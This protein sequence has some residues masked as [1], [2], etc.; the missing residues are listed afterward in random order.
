MKTNKLFA[1][2]FFAIVINSFSQNL[3]QHVIAPQ[4]DYDITESMTLEW[5]LG[6]MFIETLTN[7]NKI[8]SQG[9]HQPFLG[10]DII[11]ITKL[12]NPF[13]IEVYPNPT[14]LFLNIYLNIENDSSFDVNFFDLNG[15][16]VKY[17]SSSS[18]SSKLTLNIADLAVGVYYLKISNSE[19]RIAVTKKII[20]N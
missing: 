13:N 8:I 16:F 12:E 9:F 11:L 19:G 5:T 17:I 3:S 1:L 18:Y 6:E 4:G 10:K 7:N 2:A 20:K 14:S 15:R